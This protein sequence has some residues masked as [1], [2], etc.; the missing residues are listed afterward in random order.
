[1]TTAEKRAKFE[2][3]FPKAFAWICAAIE[4]GEFRSIDT[5]MNSGRFPDYVVQYVVTLLCDALVEFERVGT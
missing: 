4:E 2:K 5:L 1:M 3:E